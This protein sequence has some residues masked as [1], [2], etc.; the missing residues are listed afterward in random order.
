ME[1][2]MRLWI[3]LALLLA[4][5]APAAS[6]SVVSP[7]PSPPPLSP[8]LNSPIGGASVGQSPT[9]NLTLNDTT[10][11]TWHD[12]FDYQI[13][14][15]SD[16]SSPNAS[17]AMGDDHQS[18]AAFAVSA[19]A[20]LPRGFTYYWRARSRKDGLGYGAWNSNATFYVATTDV[21]LGSTE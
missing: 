10:G 16:F 18:G 9:L 5:C 20:V 15:N 4:G 19:G 1:R 13:D 11:T 7:S 12:G 6:P 14:N 21:S 3:V 8:T 2:V 17:Y